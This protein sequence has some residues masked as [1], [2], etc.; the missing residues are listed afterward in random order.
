[1]RNGRWLV[2]HWILGAGAIL[3]AAQGSPLGVFN[4]LFFVSWGP[5]VAPEAFLY[6]YVP[7][8]LAAPILAIRSIVR[9]LREHE[10]GFALAHVVT[11]LFW[12]SALAASCWGEYV[13]P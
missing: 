5:L 12:S 3:V 1:M 10:S 6:W 4:L 13:G 9:E 2:V 8:F 11:A 7:L